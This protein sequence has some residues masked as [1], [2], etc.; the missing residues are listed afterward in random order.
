MIDKRPVIIDEP[1]EVKIGVYQ[2]KLTVDVFL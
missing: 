2:Q 1:S